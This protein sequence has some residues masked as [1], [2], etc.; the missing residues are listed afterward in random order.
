M[1]YT[2]A[3]RIC[4]RLV[5]FPTKV[6]MPLASSN[7]ND[8]NHLLATLELFYQDSRNWS[9]A[10]SCGLFLTWDYV[11]RTSNILM[12]GYIEHAFK[13]FQHPSPRTPENSPHPWQHPNYGA[14]TQ[15]APL[16]A[17][18]PAL[19]AADKTRILEVLGT[20]LFF[21]QAIDSTLLTPIGKLASEHSQAM[22]TT[23][24][25]LAQ[26]LNY[27]ATH[28]DA[29]VRFTASDMILAIESTAS[30][31]SPWQKVVHVPPAMFT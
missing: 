27:C 30:Y 6:R 10:R 31:L 7:D 24:D 23:M 28:P 21:A 25:K 29:S 26:L 1:W 3:V 19:D 22:T 4:D 8:A 18:T 13:R 11:A 20:L 5:W 14:K 9:G 17:S 16:P 2:R 12:Q 15:F